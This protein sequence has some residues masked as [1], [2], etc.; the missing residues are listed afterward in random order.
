MTP[1][2]MTRRTCLFFVLLLLPPGAW[3]QGLGEVTAS[4]AKGSNGLERRTAITQRLDNGHIAYTLED[5][6]DARGRSGTNI[7]A[8]IPGGSPKT[9]LIG[10]HYDRVAVGQGAIDNGASCAVLLKLLDSLKAKPLEKY[11]AKVVFFDLEEAGLVGSRAFFDQMRM[12]QEPMP[13]YAVNLDIFGY[14]DSIFATASNSEGL[15]AKAL[16]QAGAD[17]GLAVRMAAAAQYPSSDHRNMMTAGIETLGLALIDAAEVDAVLSLSS[18][19]P[20]APP[21]ILTL[22]SHAE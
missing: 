7:V 5:F 22:I 6:T 9:V 18:T 8:T 21:R 19:A 16:Q 17:S 14:G 20:S 10:A 15:L 2:D 11:T 12:R 3:A 13:A 1:F 4:I